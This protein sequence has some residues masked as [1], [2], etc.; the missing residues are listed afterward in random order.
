MDCSGS[1]DGQISRTN[2][3]SRA[4][5][6]FL[7]TT[8]SIRII[9]IIGGSHPNAVSGWHAG[10]ME[11]VKGEITFTGSSATRLRMFR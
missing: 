4:R 7:F 9:F 3:V 2:I 8:L 1:S 6:M 11:D 10:T 5:A